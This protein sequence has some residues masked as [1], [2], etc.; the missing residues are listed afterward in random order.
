[1]HPVSGKLPKQVALTVSESDGIV[2]YPGTSEKAYI[3]LLSRVGVSEASAKR[4]LA[5][6]DSR[7]VY[8]HHTPPRYTV[9]EFEARLF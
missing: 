7:W 1:M 2:V 9:S 3:T 5:T 8:V 4:I 6:K